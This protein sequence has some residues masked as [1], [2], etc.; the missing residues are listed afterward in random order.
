M[1]EDGAI[2]ALG[3]TMSKHSKYP[4]FASGSGLLRHS[5]ALG[6]DGQPYV[7]N[8]QRFGD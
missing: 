2:D 7:T 5:N 3:A 1:L 8:E 6:V 4:F